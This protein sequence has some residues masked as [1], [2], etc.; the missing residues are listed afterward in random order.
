MFGFCKI[1]IK[2]SPFRGLL[3][4]VYSLIFNDI[5]KDRCRRKWT[6]L[7]PILIDHNTIDYSQRQYD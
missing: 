3:R 2:K 7:T 4:F 6:P 1:V 5:C